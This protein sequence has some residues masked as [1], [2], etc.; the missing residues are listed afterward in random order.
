M[1]S[2]AL[3]LLS[4]LWLTT[5]VPRTKRFSGLNSDAI[6]NALIL[7]P[8]EK[9][10]GAIVKMLPVKLDFGTA[11]IEV[12]GGH[13]VP[14]ALPPSVE[15]DQ[16]RKTFTLDLECKSQIRSVPSSE[17]VAKRGV[18]LPLSWNDAKS[19]GSNNASETTA[20]TCPF[21]SEIYLL[22]SD[23]SPVAAD[24]KAR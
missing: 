13:D 12:T 8:V 18:T 19:V 9:R 15:E 4:S 17:P 3:V 21:N 10:D 1:Q 5:L 6:S 14:A 7:R 16:G 2:S 22:L 24:A 11:T 20:F 23:A